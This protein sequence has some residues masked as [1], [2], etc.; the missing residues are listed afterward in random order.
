MFVGM[1][2]SLFKSRV[3]DNSCSQHICNI[4]CYKDLI[5]LPYRIWISLFLKEVE[6]RELEN[7]VSAENKSMWVL[8]I[9]DLCW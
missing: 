5:L 7:C 3:P 8:K 6:S 2:T 1:H 9:T 4:C